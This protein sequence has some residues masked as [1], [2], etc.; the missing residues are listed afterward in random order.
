MNN[1]VLSILIPS[2]FGREDRVIELTKDLSE[3]I[4]KL[5]DGVVEVIILCDNKIMT[6]GEKRNKLLEI[7]HGQYIVFIDSDDEI[8][9]YYVEEILKG[10]ETDCD[11]MGM[12]GYMTTDGAN[13]IGWELSKDFQNDTI[14]RNG[15]RFYLRKTNHISPVKRELALQ[16]MFP[17]ISNAEDKD[18]SDRLNPLLKTEYKITIPDMYH[19][20]YSSFNKSYK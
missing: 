2:I 18:Y 4:G 1:P 14:I 7:A 11:C 9:P 8:A 3:V 12:L 5:R 15:R 19:Y 20:K 6:T 17:D 13:E 16:T 10:A